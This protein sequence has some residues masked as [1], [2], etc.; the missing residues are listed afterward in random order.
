MTTRYLTFISI[1]GFTF[2]LNA[3]KQQGSNFSVSNP[4]SS[5]LWQISGNELDIASY[6][7]GSIHIQDKRVFSYGNTVKNIFDSADIV[8]VEVEL[9]RLDPRTAF[10]VAMMKDTTLAQ[11]MTVEEF[12]FLEVQYKELTGSSLKT[13]IQMKPF[14]I[15]ANIIQSIVNKD[16]EFP[17]DL[18]FIQKAREAEKH[19]VGLET[20]YEQINLIDELSYSQQAKMLLESLNDSIGV[21][22]SFDQLLDAYL[23]MNDCLLLELTSDPS[24]P[25]EFMDKMLIDRNYLMANRLEPLLSEGKVF[26][27]VGAAHLF[28]EEGIIEILRRKGY[29]VIPIPFSFEI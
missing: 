2:W 5:L 14:F 15:S 22:K 11:L 19:V 17:L 26:T 24:I 10:E 20:L 21:K 1:V 8:A 16:V 4:K 25:K 9:D 18:Y 7:Y 12:K 27:A 3:C 13:A 29:N 6:L 23:S 28:G